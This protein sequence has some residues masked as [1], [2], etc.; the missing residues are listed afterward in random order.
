MRKQ[1]IEALAA[2]HV[3]AIEKNRRRNRMIHVPKAIEPTSQ[4]F[5]RNKS[6]RRKTTAA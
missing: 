1:E 3:T 5:I 6:P 2:F 4:A